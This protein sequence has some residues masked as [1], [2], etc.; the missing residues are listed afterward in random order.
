M[1]AASLFRRVSVYLYTTISGT[2]DSRQSWLAQSNTREAAEHF[3]L[4][5]FPW[6]KPQSSDQEKDEDLARIITEALGVRIWLFGQPDTC[7]FKWEGAGR[8]G[9]IISPGLVKRMYA[10]GD[11]KETWVVEGAVVGM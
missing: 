11:E 10:N 5:F 1:A 6:A 2:S 8:R 4:T 3:S 7:E 9:V